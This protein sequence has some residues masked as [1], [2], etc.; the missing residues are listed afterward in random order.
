MSTFSFIQITDH[1][2]RERESD[3][4][5]GFSPAHA[6]RA[7]LR[8]IAQHAAARADFIVT[9][10]DLVNNGTD[11]EYQAA[12]VMLGMRETSVPPGPQ[13]VSVEGLHEKPMY[14]L[15]GNHDPRE[16]FFRNMFPDHVE[17][18]GEPGGP[19]RLMNASFMHKGIRFIC[20]DWGG[21][22]KPVAHP[23]MLEFLAESLRDR[24]PA[25]ILMHHALAPVGIPRLDS[26]LPDEL[27]QFAA[28]I[29]GSSA[30]AIFHGHFHVTYELTIAAI[31]VY[32]LRSTTFSFAP[33]GDKVLFV[34]RPP[35]YRI[36]TVS[37]GKVTTEIVEVAL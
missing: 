35:H 10:G 37:E 30:L 18:S 33:D 4:M 27:P 2:L 24:T 8:H 7:T 34:L 25:I 3:L 15:P 31:P 28:L 17:T 21:D 20:V 19:P 22:N 1:H 29:Q 5:F 6:F 16:V 9:T 32:G 11:G 14:F 36:V 26:F 13:R 23:A 12:R